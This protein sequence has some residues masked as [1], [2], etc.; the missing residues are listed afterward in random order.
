MCDACDVCLEEVAVPYSALVRHVGKMLG[1][2][3]PWR[4]LIGRRS[5]F[6]L[7]YGD[8]GGCIELLLTLLRLKRETM[9]LLEKLQIS[10][11]IRWGLVGSYG[12]VAAK[13]KVLVGLDRRGEASM[14]RGGMS[15]GLG[16][17]LVSA[18]V[19]VLEI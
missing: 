2:L 19:A 11:T 16:V 1:C 12:F 13:V 6:A 9:S 17:Y 14:V 7:S 4:L 3:Q 15:P 18:E 5:C 10:M 8:A